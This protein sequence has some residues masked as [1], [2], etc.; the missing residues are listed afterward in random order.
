MTFKGNV[1]VQSGPLVHQAVFAAGT[2]NPH[3]AP[4]KAV[5]NV[6]G[7]ERFRLYVKSSVAGAMKV[8]YLRPGYTNDDPHPYDTAPA[9]TALVANTENH[10]DV[11]P[12]LGEGQIL[13]TITTTAVDGVVTYCDICG[14]R[15]TP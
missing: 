15:N 5:V 3:A 13:V 7:A 6:A 1:I 9:D 12:H 8:Q 2:I 4:V 14:V 10:L 11:S